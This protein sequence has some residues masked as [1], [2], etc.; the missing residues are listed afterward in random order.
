MILEKL[1]EIYFTTA[2]QRSGG[3]GE[4]FKNP[5]NKEVIEVLNK[6]RGYKIKEHTHREFKTIY[7]NKKNIYIWGSPVIHHFTAM[8]FIEEKEGKIRWSVDATIT[9]STKGKVGVYLIEGRLKDI[10]RNPTRR[11]TII[12]KVKKEL[13][14]RFKFLEKFKKTDIQKF[15]DMQKGG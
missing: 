3:N 4:I 12:R 9:I 10:I 15:R 8:G 1:L 14:T 11:R 6:S 5:S 7:T 2:Q 13:I